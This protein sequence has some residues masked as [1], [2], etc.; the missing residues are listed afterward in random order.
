MTD[1]AVPRIGVGVIIV[2]DGR[3][4]V[5]L[6]RSAT[7]GDATWQFPGGHLEFLESIEVCAEREALE[8]T[9]LVV[10]AR[11]RGPYTND[12]F[13]ENQRHYV[14]LFVVAEAPDGEPERCEPEL[15]L[16]WRWCGWNEIPE[17]LFL[18]IAHLRELGYR[19]PGV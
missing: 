13:A 11:S 17:P 9:G 7:H 16:E 14:T 6:R 8:E 5:G 15:C 2:R 3:V 18:P 19:P 12:V 10:H 1:R 4:L